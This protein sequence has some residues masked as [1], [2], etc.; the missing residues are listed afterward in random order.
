MSKFREGMSLL[1]IKLAVQ[2]MEQGS[3]EKSA[4]ACKKQYERGYQ[5]GSHDAVG[6][7]AEKVKGSYAARHCEIEPMPGA[8]RMSLSDYIDRLVGEE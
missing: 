2:E 6:R 8:E 3:R 1:D 7:F 5:K 4:R